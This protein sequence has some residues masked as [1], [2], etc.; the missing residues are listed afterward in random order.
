ML[1]K[2]MVNRIRRYTIQQFMDTSRVSGIAF[3]HDENSILVSCNQSG[4]FNVFS[5]PIAG[6]PM[7]Q[8]TFS[9]NEDIRVGASFP[10]DSR[11]VY[12]RDKGGIE[13]RHLCVLEADGRQ[14]DLTHGAGIKAGLRGW[15]RDGKH[16]YCVTNERDRRYFD[17]YKIDSESYQ[18]TLLFESNDDDVL[19]NIS[20]DERWALFLRNY[21][22][23][24][25]DIYLCDLSS[26]LMRNLTAH[27]GAIRYHSVYFDPGSQSVWYS[28]GDDTKT[29]V[30]RYDITTEKTDPARTEVGSVGEQL[31]YS[32][33]YRVRT[34]ENGVRTNV[35]VYDNASD[36][37]ISFP[38]FPQ[39]EIKSVTIS[40][41]ERLMAFYVNGD[42]APNDLY[43]YEFETERISQLTNS[44]NP[45]IDRS[46]LVESE[47]ISFKSFDGMEIPCLLWKPR[48]ATGG[49][50]APALVWVHGGPGGR[51]RKGYAAAVQFL[52]NHGYVVLGVNHRG[53]SGFGKAFEAA[54]DRKQ[55]REPL[56]DCVEAKRYLASL[57]FVDDSRIG[58]IGGSFGAYMTLAGLAFHAEEFAVGVAISGVSNWIRA[59]KSLAP[60]SPSRK[61]YYEKLGDPDADE[62]LLRAISPA[63]HA[64]KIRK[65]LMV[66]QGAKDPRVLRIESDDIVAA[67]RR[68]GGTVE[69]LLLEDEAHGFRKRANAVR[70][71]Q[72][73]LDFLDRYLK[74]KRNC[75]DVAGTS[76]K[77]AL[78]PA[79]LSAS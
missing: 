59:L 21:T 79:A 18:R 50:K 41:S 67:V 74:H 9:A 51:T 56:W 11:L 49:S 12:A 30:Y 38:A 42:R 76:Q 60:G 36:Q 78:V 15:S 58:I 1:A 75:A 31:S 63:F 17:V 32:G 34:R 52:V 71:Y 55:G 2:E 28:C 47:E 23:T 14:V 62:A 13:S 19:V 46:D 66:I 39:G 61:L 70:A 43:V 10:N 7:K 40:R 72:A 29:Y 16:F 48:H 25:N 64:D 68:Y 65:P 45:A 54:A 73:I 69:Y 53:S 77:E 26:K 35:S 24:D 33:R 6:G 22:T 37:E 3:S 5:V 27:D 57:E 4:I 44:L 20:N 8:V